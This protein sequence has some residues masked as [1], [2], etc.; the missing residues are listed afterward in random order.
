MN[1]VIIKGL[2]PIK[3]NLKGIE[4]CKEKEIK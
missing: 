3:L 2:Y 1:V 4:I